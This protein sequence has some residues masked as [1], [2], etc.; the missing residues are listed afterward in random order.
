LER[1]HWASSKSFFPSTF[2]PLQEL[3][4]VYKLAPLDV[5][6]RQEVLAISLKVLTPPFIEA[7]SDGFSLVQD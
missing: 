6:L 1:G 3:A 4:G 5:H 7:A 2:F